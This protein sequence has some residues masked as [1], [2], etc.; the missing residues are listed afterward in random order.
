MALV[1]NSG[2]KVR[3]ARVRSSYAGLLTPL[4]P[5]PGGLPLVLSPDLNPIVRMGEHHLVVKMAKR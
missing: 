3:C 2:K 1:E 4:F 5:L